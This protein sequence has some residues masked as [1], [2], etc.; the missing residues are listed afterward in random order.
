MHLVSSVA[1]SRDMLIRAADSTPCLPCK[2]AFC[3]PGYR[4]TC[5]AEPCVPCAEPYNTLGGTAVLAPTHD[6]VCRVQCKPGYH[7]VAAS[8]DVV[9]NDAGDSIDASDSADATDASESNR[10]RPV[11]A[12]LRAVQPS[13]EPEML[14]RHLLG[15]FVDK[16]RLFTPMLQRMPPSENA[17]TVHPRC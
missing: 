10:T 8:G 15:Q 14:F 4:Y 17:T 11:D 2:E 9:A 6:A 13:P 12:H 3:P 5:A 7:A 16:P 1:P